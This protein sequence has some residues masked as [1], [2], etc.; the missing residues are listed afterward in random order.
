MNLRDR[1]RLTIAKLSKHNR[2]RMSIASAMAIAPLYLDYR[3]ACTETIAADKEVSKAFGELLAQPGWDLKNWME[4]MKAY[5]EKQKVS[6]IKALEIFR[7]ADE[8]ALKWLNEQGTPKAGDAV[9]GQA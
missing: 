2:S 8:A 1:V 7:V 6:R 9:Q 5:T 3:K 4:A